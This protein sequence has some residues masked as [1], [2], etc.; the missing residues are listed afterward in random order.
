MTY[1][2][3]YE[4]PNDLL[5][6]KVILVTGA[7]DGIGAVAARFCAAHGA[8]VILLGRTTAKLEAVYDEIVAAGH[9]EPGIVPMDLSQIT[10]PDVEGLAQALDDNYGK[11]DGLLHNASILG[12]RVPFEHYSI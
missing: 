5:K 10:Q 2:T 8:S 6:E 3:A 11:L 4:A 12:D 9:P 1:N 7:G